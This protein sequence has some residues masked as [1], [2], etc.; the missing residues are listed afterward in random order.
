MNIYH[1]KIELQRKDHGCF[2]EREN[3]LSEVYPTLMVALKEGIWEINAMISEQ[4]IKD[5]SYQDES[6]ETFV[7]EM[8]N[9]R[10]I[11]C[12]FDSV[13][14]YDLLFDRER[15]APKQID[16]V[17]DFSGKLINRVEWRGVGYTRFPGDE[18]GNAGTHFHFGDLVTVPSRK[19]NEGKIYVVAG[20][21]GRRAGPKAGIWKNIYRV[22]Y[23]TEDGYFDESCHEHFHERDLRR[24]PEKSLQTA[25]C[26]C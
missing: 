6:T 10:F 19:E 4:Y 26:G 24:I 2:Y 23:I 8:L 21:P 12:E 16:W 17:Y 15:E 3:S 14:K 13:W 11:I 22:V 1:L 7:K 20:C 25:L 9:Y 5:P 18:L